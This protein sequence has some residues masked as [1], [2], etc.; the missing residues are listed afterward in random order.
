MIAISQK[1]ILAFKL[2]SHKAQSVWQQLQSTYLSQG[3][4]WLLCICPRFHKQLHQSKER[5]SYLTCLQY[6]KTVQI[7]VKENHENRLTTKFPV[8]F[9]IQFKTV[10]TSYTAQVV[11]NDSPSVPIKRIHNCS[12][13]YILGYLMHLRNQTNFPNR[14]TQLI[15]LSTHSLNTKFHCASSA[16]TVP[17][18]LSQHSSTYT[19]RQTTMLQA[20]ISR[21]PV[22][23]N[24]RQAP[25][26]LHTTEPQVFTYSRIT[27]Q[28]WQLNQGHWQS[29]LDPPWFSCQR[30]KSMATKPGHQPF[31]VLMP[32]SLNS[33]QLN[34][35]TDHSGFSCQRLS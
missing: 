15:P 34:L 23:A 24:I 31:R 5:K 26:L 1:G 30:F 13:N 20:S 21:S 32:I 27:L 14:Q 7:P 16:M 33:G 17:I 22:S 8:S 3:S 11:S 19:A 4:L 35:V 28:M 25:L 29:K 12:S 6:C 10:S 2:S 9:K 18:S